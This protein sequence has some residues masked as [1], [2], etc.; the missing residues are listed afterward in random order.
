MGDRVQVHV[1]GGY[2]HDIWLYA[3]W[4]GNDLIDTVRT[5]IT[6]KWRWNDAEY[7]TRIIFNEM[8]RGSEFQEISFGIG[9]YQHGDVYR[10]VEVDVSNQQ[11]RLRLGDSEREIE[12]AKQHNF[13]YT[14]PSIA[15][16]G[17]F[18]DFVNSTINSWY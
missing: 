11:V 1:I 7:L 5:A 8:T 13:H 15:W 18:E 3:H 9:N 2:N 12:S 17:S 14:N 10:V 4:M 6:K 16:E